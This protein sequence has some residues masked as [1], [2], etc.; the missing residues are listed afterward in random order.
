VLQE[1]AVILSQTRSD[2]AVI[3]QQLQQTA[4][5]SLFKTLREIELKG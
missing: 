4:G 5:T 1:I 2:A 3:S